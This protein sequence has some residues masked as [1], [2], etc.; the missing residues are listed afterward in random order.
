MVDD[1]VDEGER[2]RLRQNL[3]QQRYDA[4][5]KLENQ[6]NIDRINLLEEAIIS[7]IEKKPMVDIIYKIKDVFPGAIEAYQNENVETDT[8]CGTTVQEEYQDENEFPPNQF[9]YS[10]TTNEPMPSVNENVLIRSNS[11]SSK[12]CIRVSAI[13]K[14]CNYNAKEGSDTCGIHQRGSM[15]NI[16]MKA[17]GKYQFKWEVENK[18]YKKKDF[19][20]QED[21]QDFIENGYKIKD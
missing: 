15:T 16:V 12:K 5:K 9:V 2:K 10:P 7:F 18:K 4:K 21:I 1:L 14:Q 19:N 20:S 11:I 13:G 3:Y 8:D 6:K 17:N